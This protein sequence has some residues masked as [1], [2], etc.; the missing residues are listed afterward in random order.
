M[1]PCKYAMVGDETAENLRLS[2]IL[3]QAYGKANVARLLEVRQL[4]P[5]LRDNQSCPIVI[6]LDLFSFDLTEAMAEVGRIRAAYPKVVFNLYLDP[7]EY[8]LRADEIPAQWQERF[9]HYFKTFKEGSDVEFEPIVRA[10]LRP[11]SNEALYN[12]T[13]EPICLTP[14][15]QKGVLGFEA[16][17]GSLPNAPTAF[18]SYSGPTGTASSHRWWP[19]SRLDPTGCGSIRSFSW[20]AMIGWMPLG[21]RCRF[22]TRCC[23]C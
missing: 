22:A 11:S 12:M 19:T 10:S 8:R 15:F 4:E 20:A 14:A 1:E 7:N 9:R 13:H 2:Q 18:V 6:C 16:G 21:K 3:K 23:S 17:G 5:F